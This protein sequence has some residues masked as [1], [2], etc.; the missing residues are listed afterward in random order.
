MYCIIFPDLCPVLFPDLCTVLFS[1]LCTVL[2]S[3]LCTVL[4]SDL[5]TVLFL[6]CIHEEYHKP[7]TQDKKYRTGAV[8]VKVPVLLIDSVVFRNHLLNA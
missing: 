6:I 4:F 7:K 5:C 8:N 1:D 3:N 2:F